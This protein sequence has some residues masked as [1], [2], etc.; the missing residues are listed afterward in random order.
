MYRTRSRTGAKGGV[1][2]SLARSGDITT[3]FESTIVTSDL[4]QDTF[5]DSTSD[6]DSE[7]V[8]SD[9]EPDPSTEYDLL[10]R[11]VELLKEDEIDFNSDDDFDH[12]PDIEERLRQEDISFIDSKIDFNLDR[13]FD[14]NIYPPKYYRKGIKTLDMTNY[15]R[16]EYAKRTER[17]IKNTETQWQSCVR[18]HFIGAGSD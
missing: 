10:R 14:G 18:V 16:K 13:L 11:K 5:Q 2:G 6:L 17:L 1:G 4:S 15:K 7:F 9:S 3:D 12:M 8:P